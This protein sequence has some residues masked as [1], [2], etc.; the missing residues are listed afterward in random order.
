LNI[1]KLVSKTKLGKEII[2]R[3]FLFVSVFLF[4]EKTC[5]IESLFHKK[6]WRKKISY[7]GE[8]VPSRSCKNECEE[9]L[10]MKQTKIVHIVDKTIQGKPLLRSR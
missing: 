5:K 4:T 3:L 2:K 9:K 7:I 6:K 1:P 8:K 10:E